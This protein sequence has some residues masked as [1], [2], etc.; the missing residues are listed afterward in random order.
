M[1]VV[2]VV[3]VVVLPATVVI[4]RLV[5]NVIVVV[6][7]ITVQVVMQFVINVKQN[8]DVLLLVILIVKVVTVDILVQTA[9]VAVIVLLHKA[10]G[11]AGLVILLVKAV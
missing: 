4:P 7:P 8:K 3:K 2:L 1:A 9:L 5:I 6:N 10:L 11:L